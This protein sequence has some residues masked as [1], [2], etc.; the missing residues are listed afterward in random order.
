VSALSRVAVTATSLCLTFALALTQAAQIVFTADGPEPPS[1]SAVL[2]RGLPAWLLLGALAPFAAAV[3]RRWPL[4][5]RLPAI[6][7]H[8]ALG[9]VFALCHAVLLAA[10]RTTQ[11]WPEQSFVEAVNSAIFYNLAADLVM[12]WVIAAI[13]QV[14]EDSRLL[15]QREAHAL[16]LSASLADARLDALRAQLQPHFLYN[17]LNT[18]AMLAREERG[19]ETVSV[20]ARLGDLLRYVLREGPG[21]VTLGEELDFLRRYLEL[22]QLRFSDRLRVEVECEPALEQLRLPALLVQPLVENAVRHGIARR[23]GAGVIAIRA[24]RLAGA[25]PARVEIEVCDDGPGVAEPRDGT[26][27]GARED[28]IGLRN[29]RDRLAQRYGDSASLTLTARPGGGTSAVITLP[30]PAADSARRGAA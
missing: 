30:M 27:D 6:A 19:A 22:E 25:A 13:V 21:E 29:T 3:C 17:V 16:A 11:R 7:R 28:G 9:F 26:R 23:P 5:L 2:V 20:L 1:F 8:A 18:A 10:F 14:I 24:R 12:Y 15:R 4:Q